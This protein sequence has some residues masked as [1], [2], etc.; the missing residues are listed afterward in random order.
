MPDVGTVPLFERY[1][2]PELIAECRKNGLWADVEQAGQRNRADPNA[3]WLPS[4]ELCTRIFN[5]ILVKHRPGLAMLHIIDVDHVE[6]SDGPRSAGAYAAIKSNDACVKEVWETLRREF[7][8]KATIFI[9]SDH[10]FS[11]IKRQILPNVV[12]RKAK[13]LNEKDA[14]SKEST[15][16]VRVVSQGGSAFIYILDDAKREEIVR[17]I[18]R[19]FTGLEGI[20]T[21]VGPDELS[22]YGVANPKDDPHAPDMIL[23]AKFG[24]AFGDTA[25][26][27]LP[28]NETP[29]RKGSHGH[30]PSIPELHATFV[31]S[32]AGIRR[33]V[34]LG[35]IQNTSVAPTIAKILGL[36]MNNVDGKVL[37]D[38]LAK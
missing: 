37:D 26:G 30:D 38:A 12:L 3:R 25:A 24:W 6:H 11:P 13:L 35:E 22:R 10:G 14:D 36:T 19:S 7:P 32:G 5:H 8:G 29:E 28:F 34:T 4:D 21:V 1:S 16:S 2:T 33:G 18:T 23:F 15:A 17:K 20:Q 9:V 27:D 31:A